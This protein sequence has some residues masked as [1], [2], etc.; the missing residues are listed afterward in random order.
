[1]VERV[2]NAT[3]QRYLKRKLGQLRD[4]LDGRVQ[5]GGRVNVK[6]LTASG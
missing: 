1:L 2:E 3:E 5:T 4:A 6:A